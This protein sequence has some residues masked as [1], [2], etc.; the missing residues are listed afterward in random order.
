M[1]PSS[2]LFAKINC[3]L[4]ERALCVR[5]HCV[6]K[7]ANEEQERHTCDLS[8]KPTTDLTATEEATDECLQE[9]ER[10]NREIESVKHQVEEEQRRLSHYQSKNVAQNSYSS[11]TSPSAPRAKPEKYIL[12]STK[13][14]TDLEY[15]PLSNFSSDLRSYCSS[16]REHKTRNGQDSKRRGRATLNQ[17]KLNVQ[18]PPPPKRSPEHSDS[19]EE[20]ILI[21]DIPPSPDKVKVKTK[22][23][24][25]LASVNVSEK[26]KTV[27]QSEK[28]LN[29]MSSK[30]VTSN[31]FIPTDE[32]IFVKMNQ[33]LSNYLNPPQPCEQKKT[34]HDRN[35][36]ANALPVNE[37]PTSQIQK[38]EA[39][40]DN[41][42]TGDS[43]NLLS[44]KSRKNQEQNHPIAPQQLQM[45]FV[46][47]LCEPQ[48]I[49]AAAKLTS[50][51]E[52]QS[53]IND[54][55]VPSKKEQVI[56]I[57]SSTEDELNYSDLDISES[58]PDEECYRIFME[59]NGEDPNLNPN[60]K[61]PEPPPDFQSGTKVRPQPQVLVPVRAP[62]SSAPLA[63][64]LPMIPKVEQEASVLTTSIR[65]GQASIS[66]GRSE[67]QCA[68]TTQC[69]ATK[70]P[71]SYVSYIPLGATVIDVGNNLHLV[72]PE[73]TFSVSDSPG[74]VNS[75]LTPITPAN[76]H[77]MTIR[78]A[79]HPSAPTQQRCTSQPV[80]IP[81]LAR[82]PIM[83]TT[84]ANQ[85]SSTTASV[86]KPVATKRKLKQQCETVKVPHDIRQSYV[87]KFTEEFMK[88]TSNVNDAFEKAL[89]EEKTVYNRSANKLKYLSVA[90]NALKRLRNQ[91]C[92]A[93]EDNHQT[94]Q[95]TKGHIPLNR[96]MLNGKGVVML[97]ECLKDYVLTEEMLIER[98]FPLQNPEKPGSAILFADNKKSTSYSLRKLCCRCGATY[99]V[100]RTGKHT[101]KEECTY[102]YGKGVENKVPGGVETRY[103]CCQGV[104]GSPG[105]QVFKLHVCNSLSM[106]GFVSTARRD[107]A[108]KSCP[109]VFSLNCEMCYTIYGLE[110][111]RVTV[112]NTSL[113]IVYDTFVRPNNE[114]IDYNTRFT[115]ISQE[116]VER[117]SHSLKEVQDALL[118]FISADTILIGHSLETDLCVLKLL[119]GTVVD[120]SVVFPHRLGSP[121]ILS[122]HNLTAEYLRKI[123][124]ESVCGHDTAEDAVACM[125][126]MI[127][128]AKEDRKLKKLQ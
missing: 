44:I 14:R 54:R 34:L 63:P 37:A 12:D 60:C 112:V 76:T 51:V 109:G 23:V 1:F 8:D 10:I 84:S 124:Q 83:A 118:S 3:S 62:V 89:A 32:N 128:K 11:H 24:L 86:V 47:S 113:Q 104:M 90:V 81:P 36:N 53:A 57:D 92:G 9:L 65:A 70:K 95:K 116:D 48:D 42:N 117:H 5:P 45:V 20:D 25:N 121:H 99:S 40:G 75:V 50:N 22:T 27:E 26:I 93:V 38:S 101:R 80:I 33:H 102:H 31:N 58:D 73:G 61:P 4:S 119:H 120:T 107:P 87:N 126:L 125:E 19:N 66:K 88:T 55:Q 17:R 106:D 82:R 96:S 77:S 18:A 85:C 21:I 28:P 68:Q 108:D 43:P 41:I 69:S 91:S 49:L 100:S 114:V 79:G 64:A 72:L 110:L 94:S 74:Q 30:N 98:N 105:C 6:F 16:N 115:G 29:A 127:W 59:A 39:P 2:G 56:M 78:Q 111:S 122:L 15:D 123:I 71:V 67:A 35:S 103:S 52:M 7:H 46:G 97:Y 13:P